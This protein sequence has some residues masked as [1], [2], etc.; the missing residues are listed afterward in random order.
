MEINEQVA[1]EAYSAFQ[2]GLK[3]LTYN[4]EDK[5]ISKACLIC[6]RLLEWN[7]NDIITLSRL[8]SLSS[9]FRGETSLFSSINERITNVLKGQYM[10]KGPGWQ[11]WMDLMYLSPRGFYKT[12]E[13]FQCC[14]ICTA[15]LNTKIK[16]YRIKLPRFAIANGCLFGDAPNELTI[17]ND[18][19]L[20]L[21][22]LA[23]TNKH[24]FSFYGG[25]HKSIR[26]WHNLYDNDVEGI[27]RTINQVSN[28]GG[29]NLVVCLLLGP[30][31]PFQKRYAKNKMVVRT[32]LVL[33]ALSW[34]KLNNHLY[35][36]IRIPNETDFEQPLII[37]DSEHVES[38]DS[39]IES[40]MEYTVVFPGTDNFS[41]TNGGCMTQ[42]DFLAEVVGAMDTT[43]ETSIISRPTQNRLIDYKGD[44]LLRAFPLQF[45]YGVGLPPERANNKRDKKR[46]AVSK[47]CYLQHL[48]HQSVRFFHRS[49]FILVLHNMY[50][51]Q[52][53]VS[54][55]FLRCKNKVGDDSIGERFFRNYRTTTPKWDK[56]DP[57]GIANPRSR[58]PRFHRFH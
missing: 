52:R 21:I 39:N 9:R 22:S 56:P 46:A 40:R 55:S 8:E 12:D 47:L 20:A 58:N 2:S 4:E 38:V 32:H 31:T 33:K 6:D 53:A 13:G 35:Q 51:K 41:P 28:Y 10:Y 57:N 37:D 42:K 27:A 3:N 29:Q 30:F 36:N 45:P 50:E 44:A 18:V 11:P 7:D 34:L 5:H 16:P 25:A 17:L 15:A 19:E 26:G 43:T 23:R 49:E 24:V 14:K 48:Q 54:V 1:E